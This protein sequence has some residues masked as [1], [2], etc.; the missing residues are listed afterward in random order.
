MLIGRASTKYIRFVKTARMAEHHAREYV[1]RVASI[2][3]ENYPEWDLTVSLRAKITFLLQ[4]LYFCQ[5]V[6]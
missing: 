6:T 2:D 3:I 5:H 1:K 4:L